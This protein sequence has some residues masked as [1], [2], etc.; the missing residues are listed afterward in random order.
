MMD[1]WR[2]A[3]VDDTASGHIQVWFAVHGSDSE[4]RSLAMASNITVD[5][6]LLL[7]EHASTDV[8][9]T[10]C[11]NRALASEVLGFAFVE[12]SELRSV[13]ALN[14]AAPVHIKLSVPLSE[15]SG[16]GINRFLQ[17]VAASPEES[18][19]LFAY[20][21]RDPRVTLGDAW[22]TVRSRDRTVADEAP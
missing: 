14:P 21:A 15:L 20:H 7:L 17:A 16:A 12:K 18:A 5:A 4:Q 9:Y 11:G 13:I 22:K 6:A 3:L 1:Q 8:L 19:G 2:D 10:L